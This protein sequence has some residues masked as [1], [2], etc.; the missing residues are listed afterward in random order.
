MCR[1]PRPQKK[2]C[3]NKCPENGDEV[4]AGC[5]LNG[6]FAVLD[7]LSLQEKPKADTVSTTLTCRSKRRPELAINRHDTFRQP[8]SASALDSAVP[9]AMTQE[10]ANDCIRTPE[11]CHNS[12]MTGEHT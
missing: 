8:L 11:F 9:L 12:L 2:Y 7:Q 10:R 1:V 5:G 4:D 6:N 3:R